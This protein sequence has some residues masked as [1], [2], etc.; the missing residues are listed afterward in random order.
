MHPYICNSL[1]VFA[2]I[3]I[4]SSPALAA[5]KSRVKERGAAIVSTSLEATV[6]APAGSTGSAIIEVSK[7]KFRDAQVAELTLSTAGLADGTY[8][9]DATLQDLSSAHLGDLV[10][11]AAASTPVVL[12]VP[13][14]IDALKITN[15]SISDA[16]AVLLQGATTV[17]TSEWKLI[18]NVQVTGP[19]PLAT[20]KPTTGPKPKKVQGHALAKSFIKDGVETKRQFLWVSKGAVA[21]SELTIS[22]NGIA[23]AAIMSTADGKVM[24]A[25]LPETVV[26]RDVDSVTITDAIGAVVMQSQF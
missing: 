15:L 2:A 19:D 1:L 20:T 24:F 17:T 7:P 4:A 14:E 25:E 21:D 26:L 22:V 8:S 23:V 5:P 3:T 11:D 6:S 12:S 13:A 10:V 16:T 9:I 18:A